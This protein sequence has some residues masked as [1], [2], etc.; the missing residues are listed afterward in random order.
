MTRIERIIQ[1][2]AEDL[3]N[4]ANQFLGWGTRAKASDY[5][6]IARAYIQNILN[7][8]AMEDGN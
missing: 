1:K 8:A 6:E 3:A 2:R 5:E 4:D 7:A